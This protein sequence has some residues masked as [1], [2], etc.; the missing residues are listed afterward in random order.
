[1]SKIA[2]DARD[3][4][5]AIPGRRARNRER[6]RA[7]IEDAALR[8]FVERGFEAT[9][10]DEIADAADVSARTFFNYFPTKEEVVFGRQRDR[11]DEVRE[12]I[13]RR[14]ASEP[15]LD[16]IRS[17]IHQLASDLSEGENVIR[18]MKT[19][20]RSPT[21]L[22]RQAQIRDRWTDSI[23][24]ALA[25][26]DGTREPTR[27]HRLT[28][29]IAIGVLGASLETWI[30]TDGAADLHRLIDEGF[31]DLRTIV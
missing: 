21:L 5:V 19:M 4:E 27:V 30:S 20:T 26:R 8:L 12:A 7:A 2:V 10:V 29:H 16:A 3:G 24:D 25:R 6:V 15:P 1:M 9:T 23:A 28:A 31:G 14:P 18:R 13:A 11:S 22:G 17:G